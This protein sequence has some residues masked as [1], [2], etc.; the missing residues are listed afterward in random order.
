MALTKVEVEDI[1]G[2]LFDLGEDLVAVK[3][4]K[5][6]MT[7]KEIKGFAKRALKIAAKL[8]VDILD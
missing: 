6:P 4:R 1:A 3:K 2:D 5:K 7:E 8:A